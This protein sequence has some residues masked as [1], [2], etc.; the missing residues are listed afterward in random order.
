MSPLLRRCS[1]VV[2]TSRHTLRCLPLLCMYDGHT[3][4]VIMTTLTISL[5]VCVTVDNGISGG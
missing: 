3:I 4:A 5:G 1:P 2:H